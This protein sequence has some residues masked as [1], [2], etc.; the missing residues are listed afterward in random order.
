MK[1][2]VYDIQRMTHK[3]FNSIV[4]EVGKECY[5]ILDN[6]TSTVYKKDDILY[7]VEDGGYTEVIVIGSK[8]WVRFSH[9]VIKL[10]NL[11]TKMRGVENESKV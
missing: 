11:P 4:E 9:D 7:K 1:K 8:A 3:K 6:A 2:T 10:Y 5:K